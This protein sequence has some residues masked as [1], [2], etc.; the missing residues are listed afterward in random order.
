MLDNLRTHIMGDRS[1]RDRSIELNHSLVRNRLEEQDINVIIA[2]DGS[3]QDDVTAWGV[4]VWRDH[5]LIF[6]WPTARSGRSSSYRAESDA[7]G[8]AVVWIKENVAR[9]DRLLTD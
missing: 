1:W 7:I 8:D 6:Q 3:I 4:A 2:T 9:D 5:E